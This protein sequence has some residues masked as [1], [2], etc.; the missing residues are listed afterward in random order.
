MRPF[1]SSL[2]SFETSRVRPDSIAAGYS[3]FFSSTGLLSS[4]FESS[5]YV[6]PG[7]KSISSL[8]SSGFMTV[9][10]SLVFE[11]EAVLVLVADEL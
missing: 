8:I 11:A 2:L 5:P 9:L 7:P 1:S 6:V 3:F 10:L 4:A